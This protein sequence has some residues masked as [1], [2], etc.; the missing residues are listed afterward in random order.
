L[1]PDAHLSRSKTDLGGVMPEKIVDFKSLRYIAAVSENKTI[2]AAAKEL[3]ISQPSLSKYLSNLANTMNVKLFERIEGKVKLTLAGERYVNA[4]K[5]ILYLVPGLYDI[6]PREVSYLRIA[7]LPSEETYIHPFAI[8]QFCEKHPEYNIVMLET[9]KIDQALYAGDIDLTITNYKGHDTEDGEFIS[10]L[11]IKDE[12]LLVTAGNHPVN[13]TAIW[14]PGCKRPWVDINLLHGE[15]FVQLY[16][17]QSI[18]KISDELLKSEHIV[19]K[20]LMQTRSVFN[21]IRLAA[22]GAAVC[23]ASEIGMRYYEFS[24]PPSFFSIG[25]PA[26]MEV[27]CTYNKKHNKTTQI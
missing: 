16:P 3:G 14:K 27:Y 5:R 23:F 4:A 15:Q 26:I 22:T 1:Y 8:K 25:E 6:K 18:Q 17:D 19:P 12:V 2:L 11:L 9:D 13:K 7:Q 20:V 21:A 24:E 10:K